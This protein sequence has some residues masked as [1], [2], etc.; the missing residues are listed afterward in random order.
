MIKDESMKVSYFLV[1][2]FS[3]VFHFKEFNFETKSF[4]AFMIFV[5]S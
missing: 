5:V 1:I 4:V 3:L 2:L